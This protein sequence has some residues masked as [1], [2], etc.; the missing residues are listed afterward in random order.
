MQRRRGRAPLYT[1]DEEI[2][3][4]KTAA[5]FNAS[6]MDHLRSHVQEGVSTLELDRLAEAFT[7]DHGHTPACLGYG[8]TSTRPPYPN[9]IC[10]SVNNV[11]CHGIPNETPLKSG[12][13]VNV[14][15][16]TIVD[17]WF[18]DQSETF[19]IGD[20]APA[21]KRLVQVTFDAMWKGIRAC[22]V[23]GRI[24]D[25][26]QAIMDHAQANGFSVVREYQGHGIGRAFHQ[27]PDVPHFPTPSS[28]RV[29]L[30]PG[31]CF[32]IEPMLNTGVW[33]TKTDKQDLWTVYTN[34]GGLSAQFEHMVLIRE[35]GPEVLTHTENGPREGDT[36]APVA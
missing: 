31:M 29:V 19:M 34:D 9:T 3:G 17:G 28:N 25:I 24:Y 15:L 2:A 32:T 22:R 30:R 13:I 33:Q 18:G 16:T 35:D 27:D 11:V 23:G 21:A 4:L 14:D 20:V 7:R 36:L 26:G 8:G 1:T 5:R 10:T 6:L 12:D